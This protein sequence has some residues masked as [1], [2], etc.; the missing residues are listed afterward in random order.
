[1]ILESA[2]Y[3]K[4]WAVAG[5]Q[6]HDLGK[7]EAGCQ[8]EIAP[9]TIPLVFYFYNSCGSSNH[10]LNRQPIGRRAHRSS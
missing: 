8:I 6:V 2:G 7:L 5:A 4:P 1:V 3:E 9:S 10:K